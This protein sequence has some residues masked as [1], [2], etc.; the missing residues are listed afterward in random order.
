M[1]H[2]ETHTTTGIERIVRMANQIGTFF[3]SKPHDE[4]VAGTA[5]HINKFWEP[6]M[7]RHFFEVYDAG[8]EGLLPIVK[9]AAAKIRRPAP[10]EKP[11]A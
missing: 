11:A 8:G 4:G 9:E 7:R 3:L 1:S 10:A 6:R 5:E 2:D